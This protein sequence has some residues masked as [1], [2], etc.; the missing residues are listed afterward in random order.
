MP[1]H[2]S[3]PPVAARYSCERCRRAGVTCLIPL[4]LRTC[5]RCTRLRRRCA[6]R[7][8]STLPISSIRTQIDSVRTLLSSIL[9]SL[10][11]L[12][13][14]EGDDPLDSVDLNELNPCDDSPPGRFP[15]TPS[16]FRNI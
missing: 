2:N 1:N 9:S 15:V 5:V 11:T 12:D 14:L 3:L 13:A 4:G 10:R 7:R 6:T 8:S 16:C